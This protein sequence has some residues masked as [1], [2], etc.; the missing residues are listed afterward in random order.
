MVDATVVPKIFDKL[1]LTF[2]LAHKA[3]HH[4]FPWNELMTITPKW[5]K[6]LLKVGPTLTA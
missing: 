2:F 3:E 6:T 4:D 5:F 1:H